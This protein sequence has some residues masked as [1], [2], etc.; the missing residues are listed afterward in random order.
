[1]NLNRSLF[2]QVMTPNYSPAEVIPVR[3]QGSRVW[4]QDDR[5]YIDLAGGI[6]VTCLGH[7]HP[8]MVTALNEQANKI[9]HISNV[10]TNEPALQLAQLLT[11][12]TF[13]DRVYF[14]NSGAEANEAALKLARRYAFDKFGAEKDGIISFK[15]GFHGRTL[16]TVSV[17]GKAIYSE[18][19]GPKPAAIE[20]AVYND[21]ASLEA[22]ISDQTCAVMVEPI[23]GEGGIIPGDQA[24]LEGVR[25]LCDRHQAILIFDEVQTGAGRTGDLYA[26]MNYGVLPDILTTAK[27]MGGGFP[28]GAM[29]ATADV[30]KHLKVGTH[31]STY[32]GNPLACAVAYATLNYVNQPS[33]LEGVVERSAMM[34]EALHAI[35]ERH[36]C[37]AEIRGRGML[38]G[39]ELT[40]ELK[41]RARELMKLALS[42]GVMCLVAGPDV[43]R[44]TPSLVIEPEE[45]TEGMAR[46]ARAVE[47]IC[48][49]S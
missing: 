37:F 2:D 34:M 18:G 26:Y 8:T 31:G 43:M 14:A 28:V 39:A 47:E 24:F 42:Q 32:G 19:F 45:I 41:G 29:L 21:L 44:F 36:H 6:A 48:T 16:F 38:I 15:R 17:G 10:M 30:A 1:M 25:E 40:D 27:S 23:Q 46:L 12:S 13:A 22:L 33:I 3:G 11:E 20:H 5:E 35:N 9:W 49:P 7:C 4:D